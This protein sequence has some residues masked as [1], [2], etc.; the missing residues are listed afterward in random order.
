M[1]I[2]ALEPRA[3]LVFLRFQVR[4]E[5]VCVNWQAKSCRTSSGVNCSAPASHVAGNQL[6]H[7]ITAQLLHH[8]PRPGPRVTNA[9]SPVD[10]VSWPISVVE[11]VALCAVQSVWGCD[12]CLRGWG[13][14]CA[15][16][17]LRT[18]TSSETPVDE[19][20]YSL[21]LLICNYFKYINGIKRY[22]NYLH[23]P[24]YKTIGSWLC[25]EISYDFMSRGFQVRNYIRDP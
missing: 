1:A 4:A 5:L 9:L 8:L 10:T 7:S 14:G 17:C 21:T 22:K 15:D 24:V 18:T 11:A 16:P 19:H 23:F 20:Q 25:L 2:K 3:K 13:T 12:R 6:P